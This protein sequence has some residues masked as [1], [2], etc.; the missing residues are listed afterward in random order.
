M[1][2]SYYDLHTNLTW[3]FFPVGIYNKNEY[4][5]FKTLVFITC[6]KQCN[7]YLSVHVDDVLAFIKK[8]FLFMVFFSVIW[9]PI[10]TLQF[11]YY[12]TWYQFLYYDIYVQ[13]W[14]CYVQNFW[15][16]YEPLFSSFLLFMALL[17]MHKI[18]P[19]IKLIPPLPAHIRFPLVGTVDWQARHRSDQIVNILWKTDQYYWIHFNI[20]IHRL[21]V[22]P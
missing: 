1:Q 16:L 14:Y 13:I 6:F 15:Q 7:R 8:L 10:P 3:H 19:H 17:L 9:S 4:L 2:D 18:Q 12:I 22:N 5:Q 11:E 21:L 20:G